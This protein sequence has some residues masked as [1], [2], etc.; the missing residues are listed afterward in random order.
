M[1]CKNC[2]SER[3]SRNG[4]ARGSQRFKCKECGLNFIEGDRRKNP[5]TA[6]KKALCVILYSFVKTSF[7]M[8]GKILGH[9]PSLIYRWVA[10]AMETTQEPHF[11]SDIQEIEFDEMWHFVQKKIKN[12]GSSK[13]WNVAAG[14]LLPGLQGVVMLQRSQKLYDKVKHLVRKRR[15]LVSEEIYAKQF[16]LFMPQ[17]WDILHKISELHMTGLVA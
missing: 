8:L 7:N 3:Y 17:T 10:E 4:R 16:A 14:E 5:K 2:Q 11:S 6:I 1:N 12:S 15:V 9:A 13:R